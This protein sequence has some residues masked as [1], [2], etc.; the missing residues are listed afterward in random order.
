M[1]LD[2]TVDFAMLLGRDNLIM[3]LKKIKHTKKRIINAKNNRKLHKKG[4]L[5]IVHFLGSQWEIIHKGIQYTTLTK[6]IQV[7]SQ[8]IVTELFWEYGQKAEWWKEVK[9]FI[10]WNCRF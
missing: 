5:I 1:K 7:L 6:N 10:Y 3:G 9:F 4:N 2:T 8:E